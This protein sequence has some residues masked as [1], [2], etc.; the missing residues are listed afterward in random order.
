[1]SPLLSALVAGYLLTAHAWPGLAAGGEPRGRGEALLRRFGAVVLSVALAG[2]A[3]GTTGLAVVAACTGAALLVQLFARRHLSSLRRYATA[4]AIHLVGLALAWGLL[5]WPPLTTLAPGPA[6]AA[7]T[8]SAPRALDLALAVG[9]VAAV[10][11]GGMIVTALV[12]R[13][14]PALPLDPDTARMGRT[15]GVLERALMLLLVSLGQWGAVGLVVA[16]KSLARFEALKERHFAEYY[17]IGTLT[18]L[19]IAAVGGLALRLVL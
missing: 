12:L 5:T 4:Q 11:R 3:V 7:L 16:A 13:A 9:L 18:S 2:L 14:F 1:M 15:I 8:A 17:L 6:P 10:L 19:L